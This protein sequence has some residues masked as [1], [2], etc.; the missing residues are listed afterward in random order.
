MEPALNDL[1]RLETELFV[2]RLALRCS[3]QLDALN[4]EIFGA[5]QGAFHQTLRK[6]STSIFRP[7][8][9][10][11]DPRKAISVAQQS[12]CRGDSI[13]RLNCKTTQRIKA[14]HHFPII[15]GLI[16]SGQSR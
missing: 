1:R 6:S 15:P 12:C 11:S 5:L 9:H 4:L 16:P 13:V 3:V 2:E 10:H 8:Q 7:G 14:Q